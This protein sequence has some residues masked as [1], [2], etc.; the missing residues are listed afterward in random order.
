MQRILDGLTN[1]QRYSRRN[2]EKRR[3]TY[4]K[5]RAKNAARLKEQRKTEYQQ[6]PEAFFFSNISRKYGV[7]RAQYEEMLANQDGR[8]AICGRSFAEINQQRRPG[9]DH[10]HVT[11]KVRGILCSRCNVRLQS[12]EDQPWRK[13]AETYLAASK[14]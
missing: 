4:L 6:N 11:G 3:A 13:A 5:W 14:E 10:C 9:V 7:S 1:S 12:I 8:C 2:P